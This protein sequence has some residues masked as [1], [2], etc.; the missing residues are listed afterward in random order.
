MRDKSGQVKF[1]VR[2]AAGDGQAI[3]EAYASD[4]SLYRIVPARVECPAT[5][6]EL[7]A[8]VVSALADGLPITPRG[9][10]TGLSGGALGRS[11]VVDCSRLTRI[12]SISSESNTVTCQPGI[13]HRDLN[14]ALKPHRLFFPPDPSSGDSCQIGGM[15]ANNSSGPKSVKYGLTSDYVERLTVIGNDGIPVELRNWSLQSDDWLAFAAA[16]PEYSTVLGLLQEHSSIIRE[17]WPRVRKN[18]AGYNLLQVVNDL[19]NGRFNLPALYVGSEG[20]LGVFVSATLRLLP[21][22]IGSRSFR[23]FFGSLED[24]GDAVAPLLET[25]PSSL[26]IVDGSTLTLIGRMKFSIPT[27][28]E[29]MLLLEYDDDLD[30]RERLLGTVIPRLKLAAAIERA[31]DEAEQLALWA[32][33]KAI[34]P[35]LYRHHPVK[36]P[37]PFIEDASLPVNHLPEFIAWVRGR[38]EREGLTFGLFGHIGDGNLHIRPLLDLKRQDDFALMKNLYQEVYDKIFA[39]GGSSTAEHADG[40]LRAPVVRRLYGD[41]I[42]GLFQRIKELLDPGGLF[43]PDV[44]LSEKPFTENLD[45]AKLE[46]TCAACGKCNGYCPAFDIFRREDM[47]PRGWLRMMKIGGSAEADI[48]PFYRYCLN[49][50]NC[51][52]V[53]PA[54]VDIAAEILTFKA[55]H[56]QK[57]AKVIIGLF[58]RKNLFSGLLAAGG[59]AGPLVSSRMGKTIVGA[60]GHWP[61]GWD[62]EI[63]LPQPARKTLRQRHPELG[64]SEGRIAFFHGCADNYFVSG[65]GDALIRVLRS[66]GFDPVMPPQDCCGLPMEVYGHRQNLIAKA[67]TNID[68]LE[69]FESVVFTCASCLHRLADYHQLFQPGSEYHRKAAALKDK[70]FDV[71]Q[72]LNRQRIEFPKDH[73]H[74]GFTLT[75]H[76]PCHLRAA[77][78]EK[79]PL[80]LLGRI[81]GIEIRHPDLAGRCCGQAGSFGYVHYREGRAIFAAKRQEYQAMN[82]DVIVSSCPSCISKIKAEMG[83]LVRVCHPIEIIA[84]C[85]EGRGYR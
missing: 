4:A 85:I 53:C 22:P 41:E 19:D 12:G 81:D 76:H 43:N 8:L 60:V 74:H 58:D 10:G 50:K 6:R 26:E 15:L 55:G 1:R 2:A 71:C 27:Q 62:G 20:T 40:R 16:H 80:K 79:E 23:L 63:T 7:T 84:D 78:L 36:R 3:R 65:A 13:I 68:A 51:T 67:K 29:A 32:A 64:R 75:Y 49:C 18:S 45:L 37:V 11:L 44:L 54:G 39:L 33:R 59:L 21:L 61:F 72:F 57:T 17:K 66:Y 28:A 38:L 70:V 73:N 48:E 34:T 77:G 14:L 35:T 25:E 47:S 24:A 9:G 31:A 82:A 52:A 69:P 5:E 46:L 42:Y 30:G 56:P 83:D